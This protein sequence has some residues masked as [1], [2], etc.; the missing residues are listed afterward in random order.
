MD[1]H[2]DPLLCPHGQTWKV[3][4][5]VEFDQAASSDY[6]TLFKWSC[7]QTEKCKLDY[8]LLVSQ[9]TLEQLLNI[10]VRDRGITVNCP[11]LKVN[12]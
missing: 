5:R 11:Y 9:T 12:I 2:T 8:F 6:H 1:K 7:I 10:C 4:D 3:V